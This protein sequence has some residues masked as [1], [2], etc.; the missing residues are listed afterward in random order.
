MGRKRN[1]NTAR[2]KASVQNRFV[3]VKGRKMN[4]LVEL[5]EICKLLGMKE[6]IA[7]RKASLGLLPFP[8]FRIS[9]TRKGPWMVKRE[10]LNAY[11]EREAEKAARLH[12]QMR[13]VT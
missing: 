6:N 2:T 9:G 5:T 12:L 10:E 7:K 4:D 13:G 11:I 8:A 3:R 1:L